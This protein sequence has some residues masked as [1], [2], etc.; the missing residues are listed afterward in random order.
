MAPRTSENIASLPDPYFDEASDSDA[1]I[2]AR[3]RPIR[4]VGGLRLRDVALAT[5][6]SENML[7]KIE[8]G[9]VCPSVNMLHRICKVLKINISSLFA[10]SEPKCPFVQ[11]LGNRPVLGEES[12]R[13]GR[14]LALES[15]P[16]HEIHGHLQGLVHT[17]APGTTSDGQIQRKGEE[18]GYLVEGRLELTVGDQPAALEAGD[19]FFFDSRRPHSYRNPGKPVAHV[20]WVNSPTTCYH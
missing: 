12:P 3:L 1:P 11:R 13:L 20:V 14:G 2:G 10:V 5:G 19:S 9:H 15:L 4:Q 6:C 17:V 7:S 16:P 18:L 8:T